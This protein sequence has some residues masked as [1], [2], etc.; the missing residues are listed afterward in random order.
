M[1]FFVIRFTRMLTAVDGIGR[2]QVAFGRTIPH[3]LQIPQTIISEIYHLLQLL[4]VI[5]IFRLSEF[6]EVLAEIIS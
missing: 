5:L 3:I 6:G 1:G 2:M 4:T